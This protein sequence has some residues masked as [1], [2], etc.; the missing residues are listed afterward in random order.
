MKRKSSWI[1]PFIAVFG[2]VLGSGVLFMGGATRDDGRQDAPDSR[3]I[4]LYIDYSNYGDFFEIVT[5]PYVA[6]NRNFTRLLRYISGRGDGVCPYIFEWFFE[7]TGTIYV[8]PPLLLLWVET[9]LSAPAVPGTT[10]TADDGEPLFY[11]YYV[12]VERNQVTE[13]NDMTIVFMAQ[14]DYL[15]RTPELVVKGITY[16]RQVGHHNICPDGFLQWGKFVFELPADDDVEEAIRRGEAELLIDGL[17]QRVKARNV[18]VTSDAPVHI[19][20]VDS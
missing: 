5:I 9:E 16:S 11:I 3:T 4:A 12:W 19:V 15:P 1:V 18:T 2:I 6:S 17:L 8:R 13:L 7:P 14:S 20:V 10:F